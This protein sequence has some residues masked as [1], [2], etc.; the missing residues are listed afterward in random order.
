M[1]AGLLTCLVLA[2]I[3]CKS[4]KQP[5]EEPLREESRA[6]HEDESEEREEQDKDRDN[7]WR[8]QIVIVGQGTVKTFGRTFDCTSDGKKQSGTCGPTLIKF[9][10]LQPPLMR[11]TGAAGWRFDHWESSIRERNGSSSPRTGPMPDGEMYM[12]GFGYADN[13]A[14]E[15]VKAVFVRA[16]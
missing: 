5:A 8:A 2:V 12:N 1:R 14:L 16:K 6:E 3:G 13:G 9:K 10:E 7:F 11:A 4:R 15:T